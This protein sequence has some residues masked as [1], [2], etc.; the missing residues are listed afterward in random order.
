MKKN[1]FGLAAAII[2]SASTASADVILQDDGSLFLPQIRVGNEYY[3]AMLQMSS[4]PKLT[5]SFSLED[6]WL[7]SNKG[8]EHSSFSPN[9]GILEIPRV[10]VGNVSYK[11]N[12]SMVGVLGKRL[13]LQSLSPA[14][15][16]SWLFSV[17]APTASLKAE[18]NYGGKEV[19]MHFIINA[20]DQI[21]AFSDRPHRVAKNLKNGLNGFNEMYH[22][23]DFQDDPPNVTFSG[24]NTASGN[25][26]ATIFEM[27]GPFIFEGQFI[28]PVHSAVGEMK[29]P[30][31]GEYKN[32]S[33]MI[34]SWWGDVTSTVTHIT[35]TVVH[36][37]ASNSDRIAK[38][39]IAI[40]T[41]AGTAVTCSVGEVATAGIDTPACVVGIAG[42]IIATGEAIK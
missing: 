37:I 1:I 35:S 2:L 41:I 24:N 23:S 14:D 18:G 39:G 26:E 21:M 42:S 25:E 40:A 32:V 16:I 31:V 12:L 15:Q 8:I 10:L 22:S 38:V 36:E 3:A 7:V 27:T 19:G 29:L 5:P 9:A 33:F 4:F 34:D 6:A 17:I 11:I 28:M 30:S 20:S 13:V